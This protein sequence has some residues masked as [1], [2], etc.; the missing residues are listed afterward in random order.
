VKRWRANHTQGCEPLQKAL[1][2]KQQ[3][4]SRNSAAASSGVGI[5]GAV[6][7]GKVAPTRRRGQLC[8]GV[9]PCRNRESKTK[10]T[11]KLILETKGGRRRIG[12][13]SPRPAGEKNTG[14]GLTSEILSLKFSKCR[15]KQPGALG[16]NQIEG[17]PRSREV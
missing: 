4:V 6:G 11:R 16:T 14:E 10:T 17:A 1:H 15:K 12:K 2:G 3:N 5:A 7:H 8:A 13:G 9:L